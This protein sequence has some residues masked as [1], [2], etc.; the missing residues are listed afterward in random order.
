MHK[1]GIGNHRN[2]IDPD[3][4]PDMRCCARLFIMYPELREDEDMSRPSME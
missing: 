3:I 2:H 1:L 4:F